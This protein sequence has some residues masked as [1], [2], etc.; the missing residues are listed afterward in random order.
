MKFIKQNITRIVVGAIL[1]VCMLIFAAASY[2]F[3]WGGNSY[4]LESLCR[5]E[6][7]STRVYAQGNLTCDTRRPSG[8]FVGRIGLYTRPGELVSMSREKG[9][10][11]STKIISFNTNPLELTRGTY[12]SRSYARLYTDDFSDSELITGPYSAD[13][14]VLM[15]SVDGSEC[16]GENTLIQYNEN[17]ESFGCEPAAIDQGIELD[18]IAAIGVNGVSGYIRSVEAFPPVFTSAE[19]AAA[20]VPCEKDIPIYASDGITVLDTFHIDDPDGNETADLS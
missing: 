8:T 6:S 13:F 2:G 12:R 4:T 20:Y 14:Q 9:N 5:N 15:R 1:C 16:V 17:G 11:A 10:T 19:E 7:G 18:L 3:D